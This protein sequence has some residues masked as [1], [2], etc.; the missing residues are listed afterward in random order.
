[1]IDC[2]DPDCDAGYECSPPVPVGWQGPVALWEGPGNAAP[3]GCGSAG[4]FPAEEADGQDGLIVSGAVCSGCGCSAP[5]GVAC[6]VATIGLYDS[7]NCSGPKGQ[8]TVAGDVCVAFVTT[9]IDPESVSLD[10]APSAGGACLPSP[11][12]NPV[13]P[14]LSWSSRARACGDADEGGGCGAG[15]CL[16]RP[17]APF[18]EEPCIYAAG[19]VACPAGAWSMRVVYYQDVADTRACTSCSCGAPSGTSCNGNAKLYTDNVC[20]VDQVTVPSLGQCAPLPPDPTPPPP[21]YLSLR[22]VLYHGTP[23]AAGSCAASGGAPTGT[24]I[25]TDPVTFCCL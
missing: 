17:A 12:G 23:T 11:L 24:A 3:P 9:S 16:P 7:A 13:L 19:D 18:A 22:S 21:P 15:A 8:L 2:A 6:Q 14:P 20:S 25:P 10:A 1:M 4:G 5:Q